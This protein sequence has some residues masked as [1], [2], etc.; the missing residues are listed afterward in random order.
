[1]T[2]ELRSTRFRREREATWYRLEGLVAR[3]ERRGVR[4][5]AGTDLAELATLYRATISSLSV[6]R[7]ISLD[8][9]LLEYLEG[10]C[11]RAYFVV[12][13]PRRRIREMV[14]SLLLRDFPRAVRAL[15]WHV[16]LAGLLFLAGTLVGYQLVADDPERFHSFVDPSLSSGRDPSADTEMLR[17]TLYDG[18]ELSGESL[19][20]FSAYLFQHNAQV[21]ILC[22]AVGILAGLPVFLLM[23]SNGLMLG[24]FSWLFHSR[25]L[26]LDWWGWVLPHGITELLAVVLCG[27]AGFGL[28]Q[29]LLFP[30]ARRRLDSLALR[31][32]Q[33]GTVVLGAILML[34]LA[35]LI[36]GIFRQTVTDI[37][38]RYAVIITTSIF[39]IAYFGYGGRGEV[40]E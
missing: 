1:M 35:G 6:A 5:L 40:T 2:S 30:G 9:N 38:V 31:G 32:R 11:Q 21:G 14:S 12:Y 19:G 10:L 4:A 23:G 16:V 24:A 20:E 37:T 17:A 28:A 8:R 36:E 39:W 15:R 7:A 29:G 27:G 13:G 34:L 33:A 3:A 18:D 22:F 26:G 25:G